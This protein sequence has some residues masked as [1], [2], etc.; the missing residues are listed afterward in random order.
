[1]HVYYRSISCAYTG[2]GSPTDTHLTLEKQKSE[3]N[4]DKPMPKP[5]KPQPPPPYKQPVQEST[6]HGSPLLG[7]SLSQEKQEP[8]KLVSITECLYILIQLGRS[9]CTFHVSLIP[10]IRHNANVVNDPS[11]NNYTQ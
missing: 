8:R 4:R 10:I 1:M 5:R 7:V 2:L 6:R 3:R 11:N 9:Q